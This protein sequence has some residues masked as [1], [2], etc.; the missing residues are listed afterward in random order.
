MPS[1]RLAIFDMAGTVVDEDNVVYKTLRQVLIDQGHE[2]PLDT[3][4]ALGAGKE[5]HQAL[6]DILQQKMPADQASAIAQNAF[7]Q[8]KPALEQ[9]YQTLDIKP[10]RG[11][12]EFIP[13]LRARGVKVG[14]NTGYDRR[15]AVN[16]LDKLG[17]VVGRDIDSLVTADDVPNGRPHA[18]AILKAMADLG[19]DDPA[20]VLKAGDSAID[21]EEGR[22]AGCGI[23]V[24]VLSGAQGREQLESAM[25]TYVLESVTSLDA[26]D[27]F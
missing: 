10:I 20:Q 5:K 3:V 9:A 13:R 21:V 6:R 22:N 24:G 17:W 1:I 27:I 7:A 4:F 2:F 25:P 26:L 11:V 16:L 18:D 8:F 19:I 12:G 23:T 14:L 15:T